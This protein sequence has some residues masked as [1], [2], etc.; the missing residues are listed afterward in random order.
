[1]LKHRTTEKIISKNERIFEM[2]AIM[3]DGKEIKMMTN[4]YKRA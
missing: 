3:P 1:M 4:H 2:F